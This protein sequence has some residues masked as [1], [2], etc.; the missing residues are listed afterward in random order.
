MAFLAGSWVPYGSTGSGIVDKQPQEGNRQAEHYP[1][2]AECVVKEPRQAAI[3]QQNAPLLSEAIYTV[4][5]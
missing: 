4:E 5:P 3:L 2:H 1:Q